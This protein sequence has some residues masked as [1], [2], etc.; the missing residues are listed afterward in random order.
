MS[1]GNSPDFCPESLE[2]K[3]YVTEACEKDSGSK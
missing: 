2:N 3:E 1:S